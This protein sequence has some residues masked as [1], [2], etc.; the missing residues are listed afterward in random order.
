MKL[1]PQIIIEIK[2]TIIVFIILLKGF[3]CKFSK[4]TSS[5]SGAASKVICLL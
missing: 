5:G 2:Y 3:V 4:I 1:T